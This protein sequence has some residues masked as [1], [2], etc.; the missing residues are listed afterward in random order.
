MKKDLR[1]F[2][3]L[4]FFTLSTLLLITFLLN[5]N[6]LISIEYTSS[7]SLEFI[8]ILFILYYVLLSIYIYQHMFI[9]EGKKTR[10][11]EQNHNQAFYGRETKK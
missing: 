11:S 9:C 4:P 10:V 1:I 6:N 7:K 5:I 2:F 8:F 3:I